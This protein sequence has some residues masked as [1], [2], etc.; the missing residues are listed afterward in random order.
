MY[1]DENKK[2]EP[3]TGHHNPKMLYTCNIVPSLVQ[4]YFL[5]CTIP[6]STLFNKQVAVGI[7]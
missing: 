5:I 2:N 1:T 7:G 3:S 6:S 4:F